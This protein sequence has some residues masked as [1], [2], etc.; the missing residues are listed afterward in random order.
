MLQ[1]G[2]SIGRAPHFR[3]EKP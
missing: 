2:M 3:R 1:S